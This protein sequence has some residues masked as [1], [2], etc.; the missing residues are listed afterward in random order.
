MPLDSAPLIAWE[1]QPGP[2]SLLLAC[3]IFEVFYGG[4]RGGG[5][6]D[7]VIGDWASHA[8]E[9][10]EKAI[11]LMVRRSHTQLI[12]TI[13]R[14]KEIYPK[15]GATFH[16]QKS[17]WRFPDGARLRFAYLERDADAEGYQGH[18]YTRLYIEEAGNF[19]S[20]APIMKLRAT[21]RSAAGVRVGMRLT[22]NPGGPGHQWIKS[23][24]IDP[25]PNGLRTLTDSEGLERVYI[26]ARV[27]DNRILLENDPA[28]IARLK[29]SGSPELVRAWLEGD[30]NV[31]TGA[32]F[33]EFG[34]QHVVRPHRLPEEWGRFRAMDWGSARP[35]SVGWYAISDGT[36][37]AYPRG[38]LI[39]YREWYGSTGEPNVGLKMVAEAVGAG[40]V[41]REQGDTISYG[42]IDPAAHNQD[43]GP[44]IAE[45][46]LRG[47]GDR[48]AFGRADNSRV[49]KMGAMGG[50]DQ[51]RSRL[52]G[53][54]GRP[55]L[56][57]FDTCRDTIRTLPAL[58]HD[59]TRPEDV[60]TD[61]EDHAPD[62]TRYAVMSRPYVREAPPPPR[63]VDF[64]IGTGDG[65]I[66]SNLSIKEMVERQTKR[67]KDAEA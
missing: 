30:W 36:I 7:G 3:P 24:Y 21:L 11:G 14:S 29:T 62:E 45:R 22:G 41:E 58:Q 32:Y 8:E 18:S 12:E 48:V 6:T 64:F 15:L 1:A 56:Y 4:A 10:G 51:L 50:W 54:D 42:V 44:S 67:R 37:P 49:G 46:I 27:R 33:P 25:A 16:E 13:A 55:M 63:K 52:V 39:K 20:P 66:S 28:Y 23:R 53:E 17:E 38:A 19:P 57:F 31:I 47:S 59:D 60:D 65:T 43:G 35:F 40:I 26:P 5:K 61:G 34:P 9:F 2:Q